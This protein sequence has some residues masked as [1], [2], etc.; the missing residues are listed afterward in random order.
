MATGKAPDQEEA[1][2]SEPLTRPPFSLRYPRLCLRAHNFKLIHPY[3]HSF[4]PSPSRDKD[5]KPAT[6]KARRPVWVKDRVRPSR[7]HF[8]DSHG[9]A[10]G[11][12]W[13]TSARPRLRAQRPLSVP[14]PPA[15]AERKGAPAPAPGAR[16]PARPKVLTPGP[17]REPAA[18]AGQVGLPPLPNSYL[19]MPIPKSGRAQPPSCQRRPKVVGRRPGL[20]EGAWGP[21]PT[22]L[23]PCARR[24]RAYREM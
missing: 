9:A 18:S 3:I 23:W 15:G 10:E 22:A 7:L 19:T 6:R 11:S 14:F 17:R 24:S 4:P 12:D 20:E 21:P 2:N 13:P 1:P 8:P 5:P 16:F